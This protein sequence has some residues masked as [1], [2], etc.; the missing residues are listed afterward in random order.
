MSECKIDT[1]TYRLTTSQTINNPLSA[2]RNV[3]SAALFL[4]QV[5]VFEF[6]GFHVP[7][8]TPNFKIVCVAILMVSRSGYNG[9]KYFMC[10]WHLL[11]YV[12]ARVVF[13]HQRAVLLELVSLIF[14][15]MI[16]QTFQDS[17]G[18]NSKV[19]MFANPWSG[20][21]L[22]RDTRLRIEVW[23]LNKPRDKSL[24][25][26]AEGSG[27]EEHAYNMCVFVFSVGVLCVFCCEQEICVD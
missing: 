18:E 17:L 2:L 7:C 25:G 13:M 6:H 27:G 14:R 15:D 5:C 1:E 20:V 21:Q 24:P 19:L 26:P 4:L 16:M 22:R 12:D 3:I 9:C 8:L 10:C 23:G 11:G